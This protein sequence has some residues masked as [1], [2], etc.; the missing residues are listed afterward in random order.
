MPVRTNGELTLVE[1]HARLVAPGLSIVLIAGCSGGGG[2]S[3]PP[4]SA[5]AAMNAYLQV[6][7]HTTLKATDSSGNNFVLQVSR[8][9]HATQTMFNGTSAYS[10]GTPTRLQKMGRLSRSRNHSP[11]L[12]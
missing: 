7:H 12:C 2:A 10:T 1:A 6:A 3:Q 4:P 8:V 11:S 9:P 5:E